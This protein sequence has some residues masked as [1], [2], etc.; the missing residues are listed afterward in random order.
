MDAARSLLR[1]LQTLRAEA[2][3]QVSDA[4]LLHAFHTRQ[5][6]N[7]FEE[8]LRRHGSMVW[9]V[10]RQMLPTEDAEDAFQAVFLALLKTS[11]R[12]RIIQVGG[13]LHGTAVR[14]ALKLRRSA[15]YRRREQ[16][17][18]KPEA[19]SSLTETHWDTMLSAVHEEV[20]RLPTSLRT[21]FILC[22]LEGVPQAEAASRLG[23][24]SGTLTGRLAKAR[25]QLLAA[26]TQRGYA[27][28][29]ITGL[30]GLGA[31]TAS[32]DV[33]L[34]LIS[35]LTQIATAG[36]AAIPVTLIPLVQEIIPMTITKMKVLAFGVVAALGIGT[37]TGIV[38]M[39]MPT[40]TPAPAATLPTL[41]SP[42]ATI[43]LP[44]PE[45]K[46]ELPMTAGGMME[47][48]APPS[49][50]DRLDPES[51][52]IPKNGTTMII[53]DKQVLFVPYLSDMAFDA[54]KKDASEY[55]K[56]GW[57]FTGTT[58]MR[59]T[60]KNRDELG[61][62]IYPGAK[63]DLT[64]DCLAFS[65][66]VAGKK[67]S[68]Q[69][70]KVISY[71]LKRTDVMAC[72]QTLRS[73]LQIP[74]VS[75][76]ITP[77]PVSNSIMI[78][79]DEKTVEIAERL[80]QSLEKSPPIPETLTALPSAPIMP[81]PTSMTAQPK[82]VSPPSLD[83]EPEPVIFELKHMEISEAGQLVQALLNSGR[84]NHG[85][86]IS[87]V[88]R[89]NS[90]VV[91]GASKT[92]LDRIKVLFS[93]LDVPGKNPPS[94]YREG[95]TVLP[96]P[97]RIDEPVPSINQSEDLIPAPAPAP[98]PQKKSAPK[99]TPK[100]TSKTPSKVLPPSH[101]TPERIHGAIL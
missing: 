91:F 1:Q 22:D 81:P 12:S 38:A 20:E 40:T 74:N 53:G 11:Q 3:A 68:V 63:D 31:A 36:A 100:P 41:P 90:I 76:T 85:V 73:L 48:L 13:W 62:K 97:V 95:G 67:G 43:P 86:R 16:H 55:A 10:C 77:D 4:E 21:A 9:A 30:V 2:Y 66:P 7:A 61:I 33:P 35:Q 89:T 49:T 37:T 8:I 56:Y 58:R 80:I 94:S 19:D 57:A 88:Q 60:P 17:Q 69:N 59:F 99:P 47:R 50:L 96:P 27:S 18:A 14:C 92:Q 87:T 101:L 54:F 93:K 71:R 23:W 75:V 34:K 24:K 45:P 52:G 46:P 42:K 51:E 65:R 98:K 6:A 78:D 70:K 26:L 32:A 64:L 79:S 25:Q 15:A 72:A 5:E 29:T 83:E 82:P 39:Q 44:V 28:A 84:A